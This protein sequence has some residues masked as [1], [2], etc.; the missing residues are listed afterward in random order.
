MERLKK[1]TNFLVRLA[2]ECNKNELLYMGNEMT[3]K[4][5]LSLFPFLIFI[6]SIVSHMNIDTVYLLS[7]FNGILPEQ[8]LGT[9][10]YIIEIVNSQ[11]TSTSIISVSLGLAIF[12]TSSGVVS[13]MR[14]INKTYSI[15]KKRKFIY[16]RLISIF[17]VFVF[18]F[19]LLVTSILLV[20]G[21]S[22]LEFLAGL[23]F[24]D[25]DIVLSSNFKT[26]FNLLKYGVSIIT[27]LLTTMII[28]KVAVIEKIPLKSTLPGAVFSM[29]L[30]MTSSIGYN[31]Y[32]NN[33]SKYSS[34]YGSIGNLFILIFWINIIAI[35][36]LVGSQINAILYKDSLAK[37]N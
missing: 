7:T 18:G 16:T 25:A 32:I 30:W 35:I 26:F 9:F 5:F 33:Y 20:F 19:S 29:V 8:V 1:Y 3:Y 36:I 31:F 15:T 28:Y 37:N 24:I 14:G 27:V 10:V 23:R 6:I 13:I 17:L 2:V 22:I 11:A 12:S 21:D 34:L 4:I